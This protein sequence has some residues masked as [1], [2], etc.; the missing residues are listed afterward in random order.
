MSLI[1][2]IIIIMVNIHSETHV[3]TLQRLKFMRFRQ[4]FRVL[5][6]LRTIFDRRM[7]HS[8]YFSS[9][10]PVS[11]RFYGYPLMSFGMFWQFSP[12][13][14]RSKKYLTKFKKLSNYRIKD[15]RK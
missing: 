11:G 15:Y 10:L 3:E 5:G 9:V 8:C 7:D 12:P 1:H 2:V 6:R 13:G 14:R 4:K